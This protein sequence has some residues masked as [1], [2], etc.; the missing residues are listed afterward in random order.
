MDT[1]ARRISCVAASVL[2]RLGIDRNEL[3]SMCATDA[4][5]VCSEKV[6]VLCPYLSLLKRS[7]FLTLPKFM[8]ITNILSI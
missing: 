3:Q 5:A 1:D 8:K 6:L 4:I 2:A 7:L